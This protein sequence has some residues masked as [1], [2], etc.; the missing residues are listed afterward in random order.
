MDDLVNHQ[1][2][3]I[4]PEH[5]RQQLERILKSRAFRNSPKLC[6]LLSYLVEETINGRGGDLKE[7]VIGEV[8]YERRYNHD[9][10]RHSFVRTAAGR[11]RERLATY[12]E[13]EG[14]GDV[15]GIEI[16]LGG[17][18]PVFRSRF[19]PGKSL[20][21]SESCAVLP[22]RE[23]SDGSG[24]LPLAD[25]VTDELIQ[26]LTYVPWLRIVSRTSSFAFR[27]SQMDLAEI[28]RR[29]G[30]RQVVEGRVRHRSDRIELS[31]RV[32][33]SQDGLHKWSGELSGRLSELAKLQNRMAQEVAQALQPGTQSS[34]RQPRE[35]SLSAWKL[36]RQG[37]Y[38]AER[39][40][41]DGWSKAVACFRRALEIDPRYALAHVGLADANIVLANFGET[42]PAPAMAAARV[43]SETA[44][45]IDSRLAEAHTSLAAV[46]MLADW[47]W[48][49]AE[50]S[51]KEAITLG[52]SYPQAHHWYGRLLSHQLRFEE[53]MARMEMAIALDPV[54][55]AT[56]AAAGMVAFEG[57][58]FARA[59]THLEDALELSENYPLAL[60]QIGIVHVESGN[61]AAGFEFLGRAEKILPSSSRLLSFC[62]Y[63]HAKIGR[64]DIALRYLSRLSELSR[65]RYVS[66][67]DIALI[68][69]GLRNLDEAFSLIERSIHQRDNYLCWLVSSPYW[70]TIHSDPRFPIVAQW[71]SLPLTL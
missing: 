33:D 16:P 26:R 7:Y 2:T 49:A 20:P 45:S 8:I 5:A 66:P 53:A 63:A 37:R 6:K 57:K 14:L 69:V 39:R 25:D 22:F 29:L 41:L 27:D 47:D 4:S 3:E 40:T 19:T 55:P 42:E 65:S 59:L 56:H 58:R 44:L 71:V 48:E 35:P 68:H 60:W 15:L 46:R 70:S 67:L 23:F 12:Y 61:H 62:G 50:H 30:V 64:R 38:H 11:L 21:E 36:Y 31:A 17:Y 52:P 10:A 9:S 28:A 51:F 1:H 34:W 32:I 13:A 18:T 43:A 24:V 54:S